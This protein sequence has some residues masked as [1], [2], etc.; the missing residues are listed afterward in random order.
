MYYVRVTDESDNFIGT[1]IR[2]TIENCICAM[3]DDLWVSVC[4]DCNAKFWEIV[5][6]NN[7]KYPVSESEYSIMNE[8]EDNYGYGYDKDGD[9]PYCQSSD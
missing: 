2:G 6:V 9:C 5:K 4:L 3:S 8:W 7:D 1:M